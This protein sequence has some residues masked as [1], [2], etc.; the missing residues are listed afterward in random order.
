MISANCRVMTKEPNYIEGKTGQ[1][2]EKW[3]IPK[4]VVG[5]MGIM[6]EPKC[7]VKI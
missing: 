6:T 1:D 4:Q 2:S 5:F 3:I 7:I